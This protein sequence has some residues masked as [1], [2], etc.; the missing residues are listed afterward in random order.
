MSGNK[1]NKSKDLI[2]RID[3]APMK[4]FFDLTYDL[5]M[6]NIFFILLNLHLPLFLLFFEPGNMI[7]YYIILGI[8]CLNLLPSYVAMEYALLKRS[9]VETGHFKKFFEGY[10]KKFKTSFLVG[11]VWIAFMLIALIDSMFFRTRVNQIVSMAFLTLYF[12]GIILFVA[13]S[14]VIVHF[15][16]KLTEVIKFTLGFSLKF[17]P[18]T[19]IAILVG[20]LC[21]Y[22]S[23]Y[24][25]FPL[26]IGFAL[27]AFVQ[28]ILSKKVVADIEKIILLKEEIGK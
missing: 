1:E 5:I 24:I 3:N 11:A 7:L 20:A 6:N 17:I 8:L 27:A 19:V 25:V 15:D 16:F 22:F 26:I 21:I 9:D 2:D 12:A 18:G 13:S 23:Q 4:K 10:R 28:E 14:L